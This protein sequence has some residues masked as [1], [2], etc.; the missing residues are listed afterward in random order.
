MTNGMTAVV[1]TTPNPISGMR[2]QPSLGMPSQPGIISATETYS[3]NVL[4]AVYFDLKNLRIGGTAPEPQPPEYVALAQSQYIIASNETFKISVDLHF[5]DSPLA[6]LLLCLGTKINVTFSFE[7]VGAKATEED[8]SVSI[9]TEKDK[10]DYTLTYQGT[11]DTTKLTPGFYAIAAVAQI[12]PSDHACGQF[13]FGF[14]YIAAVVLQVY[15]A[16]R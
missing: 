15:Q 9:T 14:G 4:G 13:V 2:P 3:R 10:F 12:G 11:P 6:R 8:A 16:F 1:P 5:N 7:G